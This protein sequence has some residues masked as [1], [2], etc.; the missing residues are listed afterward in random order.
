MVYNEILDPNADIK[1]INVRTLNG[2]DLETL[3]IKKV[4]GKEWDPQYDV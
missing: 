2:V 4:S 1:P 3:K